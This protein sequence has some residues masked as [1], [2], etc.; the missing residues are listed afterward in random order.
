MFKTGAGKHFSAALAIFG[1]VVLAASA[2]TTNVVPFSDDFESYPNGTPLVNGT[3]GWYATTNTVIVQENIVYSGLKSAMLPPDCTLSNRFVE[4]SNSNL[5]VRMHIRPALED[6]SRVADHY[7]ATNSTAIF[8]VNTNGYCMVY[9]GTNG[10]TEL[11]TKYDGSSATPIDSNA[12]SRIDLRINYATRK[13][14]LFV[15][16]EVLHTNLG[17]AYSNAASFS[18]FDA[19]NIGSEETNYL[20]DVTVTYLTQA[21]FATLAVDTTNVS[22]TIVA[23]Q[24]VASN[25]F[26]VW[27]SSNSSA[28]FFT[29]TVF[30]TNDGIY[31]NWLSVMPT[32]GTSHGELK[33]IWLIFSTTNLPQRSQPYQA[34]VQINATDDFGLP[35]VNSPQTVHVYVYVNNPPGLEVSPLSL[36][37]A[38]TTG[39]RAPVQQIYV[40]NNSAPPRIS[41]A[42]SV[43]SQTNW[44]SVSP[45]S[46]AVVD[47]TNTVAFTYLTENLTPGWHTG[48]VTVAAADIATQNVEVVMRVNNTP[49]LAWDAGQKTW[50]NSITEGETLAGFTFDVWNDSAAPAGTLRFTLSDDVDWLTLSPSGG[51]SAGT[52]Q[53]ISVAYNVAGLSPGVHT[54]IVTMTAVDD[55]TGATAS[56]S[57]L[58]MVAVVTVRGRAYLATDTDFLTNSVLENYGATNVA[59]FNIWNIAGVPRDGLRY[60]VSPDVAWLTVSPSSG[61]VTNNTNAITVVWASGN[62]AAGT[63]SG[64]IIVDGTDELTGSRALGAPK[65]INVQMTVLPR[66]PVN[67]EK[68]S[69][70]GTPYIGQTLSARNGLWQNMDRLTFTY[71]WQCANNASGA[72]L[73]NLSGETTSNYVVAAAVKGKYL[74]IAVTATDA[75]PAPLSTTAYSELV[76]AARIKATPG[77]FSGDGITDLWF[78]DPA[79]GMWRG[80][81]AANSFAEGQFG[82]AGMTEVPR[83]YN[84]DGILD[85]GLYDSAHGMWYVL[86]LPSGPSLSGSMFGGLAEETQATP[87]PEDYDGDGQAD[88]ALYWRGYWAILYS[89]L[90]RIVVV[91]P[92]ASPDATPASA[93]YDG[94][95]ITD[96][97][98]YDSGLWTIRNVLGQE[99]SVHFGSSAWIPAP[100]DYDGDTIADIC[101]FNQTTNVWS[102]LYSTTGTTTNTMFPNAIRSFGSSSGGNLPR[103]GYY[104]HDRYCDPATLHYS[105]DGDFVIWCIT[106]TADTNF[107]YRGQ[108][109]QKSI[110]DWRVSW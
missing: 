76:A 16:Y 99:W 34:T 91:P 74:R 20:D 21:D 102:M 24:N 73:V 65:T 41:M 38:V 28:L 72:G 10:W 106:R 1:A 66:T 12:W 40:A 93:D 17:F 97:G 83:D 5:W 63:Y 70:Y 78:F 90:N 98:V 84:G 27:N 51:S 30:Y 31:T 53:N 14:A 88:V 75:N 58:T 85:L 44:I 94:D 103:Q 54:G 100:G 48:V 37:N 36:T 89:T 79:T 108:S 43:T 35:A 23:G 49:V 110:N 18:G 29:N 22:R 107:T 8:Y 25:S 105:A 101:I 15:N 6:I 11:S 67:Y 45:A 60:T 77:D 95:G 52:H 33:T 61:T 109:Y 68:P 57:P 64:S 32:N 39:Y 56:N 87:V 7:L 55:S 3:N 47:E 19:Y 59:A 81:F 71:Q 96:L 46:G 86:F 42:Y 92:I 9:N 69:I 80:S 50:T 4:V 2:G 26:N 13:W 62:K 82:S 104:D